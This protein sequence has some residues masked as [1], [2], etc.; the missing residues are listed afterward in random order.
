MGSRGGPRGIGL[1]T[2]LGEVEVIKS[3]KK[4]SEHDFEAQKPSKMAKNR[5][6]MK[7]LMISSKFLELSSKVL[8][9]QTA[10]TWL[11]IVPES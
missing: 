6:K 2:F 3:L 4:P 7:D 11:R 10:L 8:T 9:P 1:V 5:Q